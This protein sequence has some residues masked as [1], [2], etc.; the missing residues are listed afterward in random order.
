[1]DFDKIVEGF[2]GLIPGDFLNQGF[3]MLKPMMKLQ[4]Q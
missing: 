1:M 2:G 3:D 4:K